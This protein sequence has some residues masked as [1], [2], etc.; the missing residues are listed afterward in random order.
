MCVVKENSAVITGKI[1]SVL[2]VSVGGCLC[3]LVCGYVDG[4]I[5]GK[6]NGCMDEGMYEG[7][8]HHRRTGRLTTHTH[9]HICI[10]QTHKQLHSDGT[11]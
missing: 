7:A 5:L 4:C 8:L 10:P 9:I 11:R 1:G 2:S 3:L 6:G